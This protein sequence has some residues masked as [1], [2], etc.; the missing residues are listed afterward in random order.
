MCMLFNREYVILFPVEPA[1]FWSNISCIPNY[2]QDLLAFHSREGVE[3][4]SPSRFETSPASNKI[5]K[6]EERDKKCN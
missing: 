5:W 2:T 6:V 3:H 4:L 1:M